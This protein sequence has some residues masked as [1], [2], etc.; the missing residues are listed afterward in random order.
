MKFDVHGHHEIIVSQILMAS[1]VV[2][3]VHF[4]D[5]FS[6]SDDEPKRLLNK[7]FSRIQL[8]LS[9][10]ISHL[11][12]MIHVTSCWLYGRTKKLITKITKSICVS[13]MQSISHR[14][15]HFYSM[16]FT[17]FGLIFV[18]SCCKRDF[19]LESN[20]NQDACNIAKRIE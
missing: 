7:E 17:L 16:F 14:L 1:L 12:I 18:L 6:I 20:A 15:Q 2:L 9:I 5:K 4:F 19:F 13:V 3:S 8:N 10:R 11:S